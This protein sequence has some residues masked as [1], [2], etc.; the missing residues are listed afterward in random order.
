[1]RPVALADNDMIW[2]QF[3]MLWEHGVVVVAAWVVRIVCAG[4]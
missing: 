3:W 4:T 2:Y 1:M